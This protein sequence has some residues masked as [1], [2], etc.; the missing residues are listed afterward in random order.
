VTGTPPTVPLLEALDV[1][2]RD[3]VS[4]AGAGGK[5]S[6]L[7]AMAAQAR[8]RGWTV[9]VTTT[10]HMGALA[11]GPPGMVLV[12]SEGA[13]DAELERA[14]GEHGQVTLLGRRVRADKLEGLAP[15]RVDALAG[16]A[17]LMLVEADGARGRSLKLPAPHEPVLPSATTLLVALAGLDVL[18]A[19]LDAERVH[20]LDRVIE[21]CRRPAG[22]PV[23]PDLLCAALGAPG[24]YLAHRSASGRAALFLNKEETPAARDAADL[25]GAR[26]VP[27]WDRVVA[28][29]A[30]SGLGRV[31]AEA[32]GRLL[33]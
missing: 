27:A 1:R 31:V 9:L 18:G 28:G 19:P 29:S 2:R 20:R 12:E 24:G 14:L 7:Y 25:V 15:Q 21:A 17:D 22:S 13:G 5:T 10:T 3:V 33:S 4:V 11:G 26:L 23:D 30:R 8:E 16:R 6:L 32:P